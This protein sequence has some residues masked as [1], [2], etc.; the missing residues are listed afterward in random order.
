MNPKFLRYLDTITATA[1]SY[2]SYSPTQIARGDHLKDD[3]T[4][5]ERSWRIPETTGKFLYSIIRDLGM[6][7]G[8]ELG[9]STGYST[10]WISSALYENSPNFKLVTI[11]QGV[12]KYQTATELFQTF[13]Y[14]NNVSFINSEIIDVLQ[15]NT[16]Q[17][18][19]IFMDADRGNYEL[20]WPYIKKCMHKKSI[21]IIDNAFIEKQ[22]MQLFLDQLTNDAS[23]STML[24]SL[25]N[26]LFL[27]SLSD[28]DYSG[29]HKIICHVSQSNHH[30]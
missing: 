21:V 26:G 29:L 22:S 11:E 8:L 10:F 4:L 20:Y 6:K 2:V 27:V 23:L 24:H 30:R 7:T 17:F 1:D 12:K 16:E 18:D 14:S 5:G 9:T 13:P 25:D 19:I 3:P 15:E 28:G